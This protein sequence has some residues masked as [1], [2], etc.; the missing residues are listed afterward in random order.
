[1][2]KKRTCFQE[3][4]RGGRAGTG[5]VGRRLK[6]RAALLLY[7]MLPMGVVAGLGGWWSL[8]AFERQVEGRM[9][10]DL[11]MVARALKQP[12]S[13]AVLRERE[14]SIA[15]ALE[16]A[17]S[18]SHV[19]GAYLYD[20]EGRRIS[21]TMSEG[22]ESSEAD[23]EE[24]RERAS[25]R[26]AE[27]ERH[28]EYGEVAGRL[29]Y[30]Y[31]VPLTDSAGRITGL[32]QLTRR[33]S[34]FEE[35]IRTIRY[36]AAGVFMV[37]F[38][39]LTGLVLYTH[40][41][42][43]GKHLNRLSRAMTK[44]A[45]GDRRQRYAAGGPR[46]IDALGG[47]FNHMMDNIE[48]AES[49]IEQR[50]GQQRALHERLRETEKLAAIGELAAG[51]AHELGNPLS[52]I[53]AKVQRSLRSGSVSEPLNQSLS[54]IR[55]STQRMEKIIRQLR[56]FSLR[57]QT[58]L[59]RVRSISLIRASV[60]AVA[61]EAEKVSTEIVVDSGADIPLLV[62]PVRVE[63]A[64]VNLLL[65]AI[66]AAPGGRVEIGCLTRDHGEICF[67]VMDNGVGIAGEHQSKLFEPFFTTKLSEDGTGLGLAVVHGIA[68]E[69]RGRVEV[70]STEG[71][72]ARFLLVLGSEAGRGKSHGAPVD[73]EAEEKIPE[74]VD[75]V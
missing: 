51:V 35:H 64:L 48:R 1:M 61:H 49:E 55:R 45:G 20:S 56:D 11:A 50:R 68:Q 66:H 53:D 8:R 17:F 44:I 9:Q 69:Y 3:K 32:L 73:A 54:A 34:D 58:Q 71:Q 37:F 5:R 36:R 24:Q 19:Y 46:E 42:A 43:F 67:A 21:G 74:R 14:G 39:S 65:N 15:Q 13:H 6:L 28:G 18:M 47:Y 72:G 2:R 22:D 70:E 75:D 7:V 26:V 12:L 29:V 52:L 31:F 62:D 63:Q 60:A 16:S 27:G 40:D 59:R 10:N 33:Y 41:R 30:S 57:Q 4:S 23:R 38:I 25:E